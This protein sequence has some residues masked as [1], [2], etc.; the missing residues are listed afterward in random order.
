MI[1]QQQQPQ[2]QTTSFYRD[3]RFWLAFIS[4]ALF[5]FL[6]IKGYTVS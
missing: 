1:T 2:Q 5:I 3:T 6:A 4:S